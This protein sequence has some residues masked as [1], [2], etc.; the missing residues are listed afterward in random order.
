MISVIM[1]IE[2]HLLLKVNRDKNI[3]G[4]FKSN[5]VFGLLLL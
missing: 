5:K 4:L 1:F 2:E 3:G